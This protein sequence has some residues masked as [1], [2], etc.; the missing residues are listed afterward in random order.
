MYRLLRERRELRHKRS[1]WLVGIDK[2]S[3][4]VWSLLCRPPLLR[5]AARRLLLRLEGLQALPPDIQQR[6]QPKQRENYDSEGLGLLRL[7][8][9]KAK[10]FE[11]NRRL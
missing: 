10:G 1:Q 7:E 4:R 9:P 2:T 6:L 3:H 8:G 5:L 11:D